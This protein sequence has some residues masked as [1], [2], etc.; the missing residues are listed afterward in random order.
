M[1]TEN[2]VRGNSY[3]GLLEYNCLKYIFLIYELLFTIIVQ[4]V[5]FTS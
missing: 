5:H 4:L 3:F 1:Y 2:R